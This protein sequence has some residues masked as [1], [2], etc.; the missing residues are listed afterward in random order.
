MPRAPGKLNTFKPQPRKIPSGVHEMQVIS[1]ADDGRGIAKIAGK[2]V[3]VEGA[4]PGERVQARYSNSKKDF[5]EAQTVNVITASEHRAVPPCPYFGRCGGCQLQHLDY[6][7]Q[8]FYKEAILKHQ[9]R[10]VVDERTEW[11]RSLSDQPL[12]YR[13]RARFAVTVDRQQVSIGF[14]YERSN[15]VLD[16]DACIVLQAPLNRALLSAREFIKAMKKPSVVREFELAADDNGDIQLTLFCN[17]AL[18]DDDSCTIANTAKGDAVAAVYISTDGRE[19]ASAVLVAGIGRRFY[20]SLPS[21]DVSIEFGPQDFTQVNPSLNQRLVDR[22][23]QWLDIK[24]GNQV[25]DFFCGLGNFGLPAARLGACVTAVEFEQAMLIRAAN[26]AR[27]N[28]L[29]NINYMQADLFGEL[30]L[31]IDADEKVILDPP[32]AGAFALC[33]QLAV[34]KPQKIAYV[35]CNPQTFLRDAQVLI[36]AGYRLRTLLAVDFFA[37]TKHL[38]LAGLFE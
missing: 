31:G 26:N 38:E 15:K 11:Q 37:Q 10:D 14:R 5:D 34:L 27:A 16:I 1:L 6:A 9:L 19:P 13:H 36:G 17:G 28:G 25:V 4:L 33:K 21:Y 12:F 3:F 32:R 7:S 23:M 24:P 29:T 30:T 2:T 20:Y 8:L 35:S 18:S 22:V